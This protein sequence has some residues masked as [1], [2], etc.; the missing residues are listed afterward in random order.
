L[1]TKINNSYNPGTTDTLGKRISHLKDKMS[2]WCGD[3]I[4][5]KLTRGL[6]KRISLCCDNIKIPTM[7]G[8]ENPYYYNKIKRKYKK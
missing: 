6:R 1:G 4:L 8:C 2:E 3:A 7:I 5:A